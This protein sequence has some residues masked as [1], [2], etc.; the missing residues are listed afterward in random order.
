MLLILF[1][2]AAGCF[3]ITRYLKR[4][5][6]RLRNR[7][8][9]LQITET[10]MLGNR[11]FLLVAEYGNQRILLGVSPSGIQHLCYLESE[12]TEKDFPELKSPCE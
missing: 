2:I 7:E 11:Q 1:L 3:A 9:R 6:F 12:S 5:N 8:N 10:K 4:G